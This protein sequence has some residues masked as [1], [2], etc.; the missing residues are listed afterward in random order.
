MHVHP[1]FHPFESHPLSA[2]IVEVWNL[3]LILLGVAL[4]LLF[5]PY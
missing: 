3:V 2:P 1:S 5:K 4:V